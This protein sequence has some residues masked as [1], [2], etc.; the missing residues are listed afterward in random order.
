MKR[1][2]EAYFNILD[3]S[4]DVREVIKLYDCYEYQQ[5]RYKKQLKEYLNSNRKALNYNVYS[6][7]AFTSFSLLFPIIALLIGAYLISIGDITLG[8]L[9]SVL[10]LL[11]YIIAPS[12]VLSNGII[13]MKQFKVASDRLNLFYDSED[14]ILNDVSQNV[15][16]TQKNKS[17]IELQNVSFKFTNKEIFKRISFAINEK[18]LISIVGLNGSGKTTL[19]KIISGL[20]FPNEGKVFINGIPIQKNSLKEVRKMIGVVLQ[21]EMLFSDTVHNNILL[22]KENKNKNYYDDIIKEEL[23]GKEVSHNATN[24]SGVEVQKVALARALYKNASIL[25]IDEGT[26]QMDRLIKQDIYFLINK[27]K[28]V[29]TLLLVDHQ[30]EYLSIS[31]RILFI[32]DKDNIYLETHQNL[33]KLSEEYKNLFM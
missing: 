15:R 9:I 31:D 17:I 32:Q 24:L 27:L 16:K 11:N 21:K 25:I 8:V 26:S 12:T 18:E 10:S 33:L 19:I 4:I 30:L 20:L 6:K 13:A 5:Q 23:L 3:E 28:G 14:V 1:N 22:G 7:I 29:K 2:S